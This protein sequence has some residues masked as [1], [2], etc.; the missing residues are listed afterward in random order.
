MN[1]Y[2]EMAREHWARWLP[3]RFAAIEDPETFFSNLGNQAGE[4]I[5]ALAYELAGDDPPGEGYL[6]KVGRLGAARH[7]AEEIV[8]PEMILLDPEPGAQDDSPASEDTG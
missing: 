8:L 7:Q 4:K 5:T 3:A 2:G 6:E 1:Q